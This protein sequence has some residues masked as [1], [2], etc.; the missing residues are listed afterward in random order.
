VFY[1][2]KLNTNRNFVI[3]QNRT[4]IIPIPIHPSGAQP[5]NEQS[6]TRQTPIHEMPQPQAV[7]D[8]TSTY[9]T[10]RSGRVV[11]PPK[12]WGFEA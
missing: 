11:H 12:M 8:K 4:D 5:V 7:S 6:T 3:R 9:I 1:T 10:T 2:E